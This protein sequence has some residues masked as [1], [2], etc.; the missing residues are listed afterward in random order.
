LKGSKLLTFINKEICKIDAKL[1]IIKNK[2]CALFAFIISYA[3]FA[4]IEKA[5]LNI[6]L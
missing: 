1:F 4:T 2:S 5:F 3:L 6:E